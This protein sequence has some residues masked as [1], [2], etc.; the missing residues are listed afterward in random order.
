MYVFFFVRSKKQKKQKKKNSRNFFIFCALFENEKEN[1]EA[2]EE[3]RTRER[4]RERDG[5]YTVK[6]DEGD[7]FHRI[8]CS[9]MRMAVG[10]SGLKRCSMFKWISPCALTLPSMLL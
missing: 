2:R 9:W 3:A 5:I 7:I 1:E 6:V 4:E 10:E 8:G